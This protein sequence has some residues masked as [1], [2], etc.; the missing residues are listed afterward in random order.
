MK[1]FVL[2][3]LLVA[4]PLPALADT[5]AKLTTIGM[6]LAVLDATETC[7]SANPQSPWKFSES[8]SVLASGW[9]LGPHPSCASTFAWVLG[10]QGLYYLL[11]PHNKVGNALRLARIG[12]QVYVTG[13]NAQVMIQFHP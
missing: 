12:F 3:L 11:L 7:L 1:R 10:N 2:A 4:L 5:S 13:R 8:T 6:S 9:V